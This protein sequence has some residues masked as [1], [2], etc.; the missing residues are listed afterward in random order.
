VGYLGHLY[1]LSDGQLLSA[2]GDIIGT[3]TTECIMDILSSDFS[4]MELL[5]IQRL[6]DDRYADVEIMIDYIDR[7]ITE[8]Q[9]KGEF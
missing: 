2:K 7:L 8:P 3:D 9:D 5:E 6:N 1:G 4:Q